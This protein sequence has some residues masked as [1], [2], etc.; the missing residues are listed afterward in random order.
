MDSKLKIAGVFLVVSSLY[1]AITLSTLAFF[2]SFW[3]WPTYPADDTYIYMAMSRNLMEFGV[4]GV[5][6]YGFASTSS[7]HLWVI[8]LAI[9]FGMFGPNEL[10]P[11]L[12]NVFFGLLS[13]GALILLAKTLSLTLKQYFLLS[14]VFLF[15]VFPPHATVFG[16]ETVLHALLCLLFIWRSIILLSDTDETKSSRGS[17]IFTLV[18][19]ALFS[20]VRYESPYMVAPVILILMT[21]RQWKNALLVFLA[22]C[23]PIVAYGLYSMAEGGL[24]FPNTILLKGRTGFNDQSLYP[25][26]GQTALTNWW[27]PSFYLCY[28]TLVAKESPRLAKGTF[29]IILFVLTVL[30]MPL[31][32]AVFG[33]D[34]A[35]NPAFQLIFLFC[36]AVNFFALFQLVRNSRNQSASRNLWEIAVLASGAH[37]FTAAIVTEGRY[38]NYLLTA[39]AVVLFIS[40]NNNWKLSFKNSGKLWSVSVCLVGAMMF[41]STLARDIHCF[42]YSPK[43]AKGVRYQHVEMAKFMEKYFG[44]ATVVLHDIG[45]VCFFAK[46]VKLVDLYGLASQKAARA[47]AQN[48]LDREM[49]KS[50]CREQGAD[51]ALLQEP[52]YVDKIPFEWTKVAKW[53]TPKWGHAEV[54]FFAISPGTKEKLESSMR[55]F[56]LPPVDK[57]LMV[58]PDTSG[59][60]TF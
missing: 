36:L 34:E 14:I 3:Q 57:K 43:I 31:A 38:E 49:I 10:V 2:P 5:T 4:W 35:S 46:D 33:L 27:L 9:A 26:I 30:A 55:E 60:V 29:A 50:I 37:L 23:A 12:L 32:M 6:K 13:F 51:L 58:E 53:E 54:S 40:I 17:L 15:V 42:L 41:I 8:I 16:M 52:W 7:A 56:E 24:F 45:A 11:L 28:L 59:G 44:D 21:R 39:F 22:T 20:S 18:V 1:L 48:R 19:T 25:A 47:R